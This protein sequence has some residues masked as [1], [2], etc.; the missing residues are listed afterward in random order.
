MPP[1]SGAAPDVARASNQQFLRYQIDFSGTGAPPLESQGGFWS[2]TVYDANNNLYPSSGN[3]YYFTPQVGGVYA[4]GSIEF[5]AGDHAPR[6]L[7]QHAAPAA[8]DHPRWLP[9][10]DGPFTVVMRVYDPVA[11]NASGVPTV[12]NL[13]QPPGPSPTWLPPPITPL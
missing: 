3:R 1:Q 10:P 6:I 13:G 2:V 12:L 4:L 7:L 5:G 9:V 11:A 8:S